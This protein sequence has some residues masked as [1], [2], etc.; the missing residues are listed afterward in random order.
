[1]SKLPISAIVVG[2]NEANLLKNSISKLNFCDEIIYFDLGSSDNSIQIAVENN[3]TVIS[4]EKV[5]GC[6]WIHAK[7]YQSTKHKWVLISDPDEVLSNDLI[8]ELKGLYSNGLLEIEDIGCITVPIIYHFKGKP[9]NGTI[10][11]GVKSRVLLIHKER[12]DFK[13][14]VHLGRNLK[15]GY[16]TID[17]A[18]SGKNNIEHYW[19]IG[20]RKLLE[21]HL[22][23]LKNEG[24]AR[25]LKGDRM[26][27]VRI[28]LMPLRAFRSCFIFLKGY[29]DGILGLFLSLFWAWYETTASV[30]LY[31]YQLSKKD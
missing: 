10:W 6:E 15:I 20:Y 8:L 26:N 4:H 22:R 1:M 17:I 21:K 12:F 16:K 31:K 30:K 18:F 19:M 9:L 14:I 24:E 28:L 29:K 23:Y 11:G 2:L 5:P 3:A 27:I 13:P 25:Y 7:Y